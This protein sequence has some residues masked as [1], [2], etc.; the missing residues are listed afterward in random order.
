V[1]FRSATLRRAND[2]NL[3]LRVMPCT[4]HPG[5][6]PAEKSFIGTAPTNVCIT[7]FKKAE[8]GDGYIL[9][10][11][12]YEGS[13]RSGGFTLPMAIASAVPVNILEHTQAGSLSPMDAYLPVTTKPF[14]IQSV[15]LRFQ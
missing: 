6:W 12:D 9:R 10:W 8:D 15:R 7:A 13:A 1:L 5:E 2:F 14:G 11:Y 4:A 3:P